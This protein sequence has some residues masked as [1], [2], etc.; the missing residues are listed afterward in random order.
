MSKARLFLKHK[1][2]I[3]I[4]LTE[5]QDKWFPNKEVEFEEPGS[6]FVGGK[7]AEAVNHGWK[8]AL[9]W[10]LGYDELYKQTEEEED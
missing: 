8:Q 9:K 3:H 7:N 2:D 6:L 10:V 1:D 5:C 4:R